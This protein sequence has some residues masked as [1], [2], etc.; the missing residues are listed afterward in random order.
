[1]KVKLLTIGDEIL[2]GRTVDTN[3]AYIAQKLNGIGLE[4]EE[5]ISIADR[6]ETIIQ[7]LQN[8]ISETD[9]LI[10]T[11][12][13]GPTNDDVTKRAL[14]EFLGTELVMDELVLKE[15]ENRFAKQGRELNKL[16]RSQ[17]FLP[18]NSVALRNILGTA[19]GIWT[20]FQNTVIINLPGVPFEMKNLMKSEVL[21]R[22]QQ[23]FSLPFVV[24]RFLS[25]S[26]YPESE[27]A[28]ALEDWEK[29][30][31]ENLHFAYLPERKNIKLRITGIGKIKAEL[32]T[33]ID[34]EV[35]KLVPLIGERLDSTTRDAIE[36]ILG[37]KLKELNLSISTAESCTGGHI[38]FLLTS[39]PGSSDFFKGAVVSYATEI[40]ERVLGV[41]PEL[42]QKHTVVSGEVAEAM[43]KGVREVLQ[44]DLA[45]STT[46]VAGP[47]KG[48]DGKEV[49]TIWIGMA[50][51]DSV[52]SVRY[53]FPYLEREDF[54]AQVSK[55]ALQNALKFLGKFRD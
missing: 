47:T 11:G 39:A 26:D 45:V 34:Q 22:L 43:A 18:E 7:A 1:M 6:S 49:G 53:Y 31:P 32:E 10:T 29:N 37:E 24:H 50:A 25:V 16:N 35:E 15:L 20:E 36:V 52:E 38:S 41:S 21:P 27:L 30:L 40:K 4:V 14:C 9:I 33:E 5:I 48:E 13:L 3:S 54:I 46:G 51:K 44:T 28:I 8:S 12:G 17:A 2:I 42:I 23:K 19:P 55:L